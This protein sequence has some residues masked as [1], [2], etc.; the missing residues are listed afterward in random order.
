MLCSEITHKVMR[1]ETVLDILRNFANTAR[2][3]K[4]VFLKYI[5]GAVVLTAYNN[6]VI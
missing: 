5:V 6:K 1:M 4:D 2:D 3:W